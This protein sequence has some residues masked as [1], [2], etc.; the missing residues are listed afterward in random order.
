MNSDG[1]SIWRIKSDSRS[2]RKGGVR[3]IRMARGKKWN[4]FFHHS[5]LIQYS[6]FLSLSAWVHIRFPFFRMAKADRGYVKLRVLSVSIS[7]S[8]P[9]VFFEEECILPNFLLFLF[10][11]SF[12]DKLVASRQWSNIHRGGDF[13]TL[14]ILYTRIIRWSLGIRGLC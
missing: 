4:R 8:C 9:V 13:A 6:P 12:V 3:V 5:L 2:F 7:G 10:S 1:F 14:I 11:N